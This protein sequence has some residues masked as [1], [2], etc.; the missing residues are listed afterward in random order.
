M[1]RRMDHVGLVTAS[2]PDAAAAMA[3]L[4]AK[5]VHRGRVDSY[6]V[7]TEFWQLPGDQVAVELVTP[8]APDAAVHNHLERRG[9]GLH[10]IA[11]EVDDID[12]DLATLAARGAVG[13]DER[14]C[15]GGRPGLRVAFVHLGPAANLLVELVDYGPA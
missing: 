13:V 11:Y 8:V 7:D 12:A 10:H 3:L 5:P 9:P 2:L 15:R 1:I 14:P 4:D 6:R